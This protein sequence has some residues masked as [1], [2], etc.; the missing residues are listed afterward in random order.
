MRLTVYPCICEDELCQ[1]FYELAECLD[2]TILVSRKNIYLKYWSGL[3]FKNLLKT[4]AEFNKNLK[5]TVPEISFG[6]CLFY[7]KASGGFSGPP[8]NLRDGY[9]A[10][11]ISLMRWVA[12]AYLSITQST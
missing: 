12:P 4:L 11:V 9:L 5:K 3:I 10:N 7:G 1:S 2:I 8:E 6:H